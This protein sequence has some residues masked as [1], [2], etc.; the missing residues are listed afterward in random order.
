MASLDDPINFM[1]N[2]VL[3]ITGVA[4]SSGLTKAKI[5]EESDGVYKLVAEEGAGS[6]QTYWCHYEADEAH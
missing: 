5:V 4:D 2:N 3:S 1:E 6:F